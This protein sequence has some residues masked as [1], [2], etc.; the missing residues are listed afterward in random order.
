MLSSH[1]PGRSQPVHQLHRAVMLNLQP[2]G[3]L[4][5]VRTHPGWHSLNSQKHLVLPWFQ[6]Q[7]ARR[8]FARM[9]VSAYLMANLSQA[10]IFSQGE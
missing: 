4:S 2:F 5:Y 6:T 3:D 8:H 1:V 10:L 7:Q 9:Q